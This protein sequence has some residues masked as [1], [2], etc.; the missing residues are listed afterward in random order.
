MIKFYDRNNYLYV[1]G[2]FSFL[3]NFRCLRADLS[4]HLNKT[5]IQRVF[6]LFLLALQ[7]LFSRSFREMLQEHIHIYCPSFM[8]IVWGKVYSFY[9]FQ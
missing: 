9:M 5:V 6:F 4:V 8:I 3:Y 7:V 2:P 1:C